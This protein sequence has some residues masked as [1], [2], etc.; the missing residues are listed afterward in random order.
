MASHVSVSR[1]TVKH[2][3]TIPAAVRKKLG[4][5]AGSRVGFL[6]RGNEVLLRRLDPLDEDFL[7][8]ASESFADWNTPEADEAFR[9]L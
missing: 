9:D 7:K 4:L 6:I 8:L 5:R 3:A 2:Q 1:L